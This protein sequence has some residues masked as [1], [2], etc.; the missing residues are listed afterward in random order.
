MSN[1]IAKASL[2]TQAMMPHIV[3]MD[4]HLH[5]SMLRMTMTFD[6]PL[7]SS[8]NS[9]VNSYNHFS[10]LIHGCQHIHTQSHLFSIMCLRVYFYIL[11]SLSLLE[12]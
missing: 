2:F 7:R 12:S 11:F 5:N 6:D 8:Q 3:D 9:K 10:E 1:R 4:T